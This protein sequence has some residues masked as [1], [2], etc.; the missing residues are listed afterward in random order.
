VSE[1]YTKG[2]LTKLFKSLEE[3]LNDKNIFNCGLLKNKLLKEIDFWRIYE[4][5]TQ[6]QK[7]LIRRKIESLIKLGKLK[8]EN[9]EIVLLD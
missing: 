2:Q 8:I 4:C 5:K 7:T 1:L 9:N 6:K 3:I